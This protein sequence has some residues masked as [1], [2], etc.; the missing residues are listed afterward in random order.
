[1]PQ[2]PITIA[3]F[4]SLSNLS[5]WNQVTMS[6]QFFPEVLYYSHARSLLRNSPDFSFASWQ[7]HRP[8][9]CFSPPSWR[10][11]GL[12]RDWLGILL[13][14]W[15]HWASG[16]LILVCRS[17]EW[18]MSSPAQPMP[19]VLYGCLR[20]SASPHGCWHWIL[21]IFLGCNHVESGLGWEGQELC[22]W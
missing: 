3:I 14:P 21:G 1:M 5:I 16:R 9:N 15:F 19:S 18:L 6:N 7:H 11:E 2:S 20:L 10:P 17:G 12:G 4:R 13:L 22:P 8:Q